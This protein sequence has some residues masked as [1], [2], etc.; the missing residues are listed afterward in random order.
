MNTIL[1]QPNDLQRL[2]SISGNVDMDKLTPYMWIAQNSEVRRVLTDNLYLKIL[3]DFENNTL[4][5]L[6]KDIYDD[7]VLYLM[8]H[9]TASHY[10]STAAYYQ[11]NGGIFKLAPEGTDSVTKTEVDYLVTYQRN[12]GA[13]YELRFKD[14]MKL[15]HL[16]IPEYDSSKLNNNS[17]KLNWIL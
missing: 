5:G 4:S 12:L 2:T 1:L 7:Y 15:N 3:D 13:T 17:L 6:Y 8:V 9:Y 16:S 14:Y 10:L 11:G